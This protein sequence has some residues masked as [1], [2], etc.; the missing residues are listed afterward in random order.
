MKESLPIQTN[1]SSALQFVLLFG[2]ISALGDITYESGRGVSGPYLALLGASAA[3][4]GTVSGLGEFLGYALRLVSGYVAARTR[5]YWAAVFLGYGLL[6]SIPLM[7]YAN[8]WELAAA[9]LIVERIGKAIRSPAKDTMLSYATHSMGRG[10]GFAIHEALDQLGGIIGPLLF[11]AVF[12]LRNSYRDG[13]SV[14]WIPVILIIAV[15]LAVRL[16]VP[17]PEKLES[18]PSAA[19]TQQTAEKRLPRV[20]W[21]YALF[22]FFGVAGFVGFPIL[23]YHWVARSVFPAEHIPILYAVAMGVDALAALAVGKRYDKV[24]LKSL[25]LI[26]LLTLL[27]PFFA[28]SQ[29]D[30]LAILSVALWGVVMAIHETT[31]RA[32]VADLISK[33]QRAFAYG[34]FNT[35]YGVA[36]LIGGAAMGVLYDVSTLGLFIYVIVFELAAL[37]AFLFLQRATRR[38]AV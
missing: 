31:M 33:Q 7:A 21:V 38:A 14:L 18:A 13:F 35:L 3:A 30:I 5:A 23:A 1:R 34:I 16:R 11:S 36:W 6:V 9:L 17:N 8:R 26:P 4:I 28:I 15:I 2:L 20:F 25:R 12:A 24:G 10:W 27:V 32:A 22:T 29:N 37:L 19:E